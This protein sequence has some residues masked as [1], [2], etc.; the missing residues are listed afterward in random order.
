MWACTTGR[1]S[2]CVSS[3]LSEVSII[4]TL[5]LPTPVTCPGRLRGPLTVGT[6]CG[7]GFQVS[8]SCCNAQGLLAAGFG[9][10]PRGHDPS[11]AI[12]GHRFLGRQRWDRVA[13]SH[14][15]L[16]RGPFLGEGFWDRISGLSEVR[17]E[18]PQQVCAKE[19]TP[20]HVWQPPHLSPTLFF[21]FNLF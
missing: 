10:T 18:G 3:S 21:F 6:D 8:L 5:L 1:L 4:L 14:V 11:P 20:G 17:A 15:P 9:R 12:E 16:T 13:G 19:E 7:A 2:G